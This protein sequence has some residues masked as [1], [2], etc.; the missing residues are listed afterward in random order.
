MKRLSVPFNTLFILI[1]LMMSS[2]SIAAA[3]EAPAVSHQEERS[4]FKQF[5]E[6][7]RKSYGA[8]RRDRGILWD[9]VNKKVRFQKVDDELSA[10]AWSVMKRYGI[11]LGVLVLAVGAWVGRKV[12]VSKIVQEQL[13][14]AAGE[15]KLD[16]V[17]MLLDAGANK[18]AADYSGMTA[19]MGAALEGKQEVVKL[20]IEEGANK[21]AADYNGGTALMGAAFKGEQEVVELLLEAGADKDAADY[22]GMTALMGAAL[23]GKQE[24]V[25]ML[26]NAGANKD[27]ATDKRGKTAADLA[28]TDEIRDMIVRYGQ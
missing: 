9:Y 21:D 19:L 17:K 22:I 1:G 16:E 18:D 6:W 8:P 15:G 2:V 11:P 26:L 4:H 7:L 12:Y 27:A 23:E 20:L 25:K 13:L 14:R 3:Q 5:T 24:V 10:D 28:K